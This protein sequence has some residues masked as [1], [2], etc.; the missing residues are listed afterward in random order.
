VVGKSTDGK[1]LKL[2]DGKWIASFLADKKTAAVT[3]TATAV[4]AETEQ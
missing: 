2:E 1:W 4:V 3:P